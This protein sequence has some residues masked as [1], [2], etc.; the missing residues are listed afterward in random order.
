MNIPMALSGGAGVDELVGGAA[1]SFS[2]LS[3]MVDVEADLEEKID[4][5]PKWVS[6]NSISW[7]VSCHSKDRRGGEGRNCDGAR[8][9]GCRW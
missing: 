1:E 5:G 7:Y 6:F 3:V 8:S 9:W 2:S 4:G